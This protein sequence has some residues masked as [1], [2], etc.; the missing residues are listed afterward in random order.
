MGEVLFF[1]QRIGPGS[2]AKQEGL[3]PLSGAVKQLAIGYPTGGGLGV[4]LVV[5]PGDRIIFPYKDQSYVDFKGPL[6]PM[7]MN[8]LVEKN[9]KLRVEWNNTLGTA[10]YAP[11][12]ATI[13]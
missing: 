6:S 8:A 9:Q 5:F 2:Q 1:S 3:I 11:V 10:S 7:A 4:R 12:I 13:D